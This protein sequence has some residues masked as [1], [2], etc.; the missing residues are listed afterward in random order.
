MSY[1]PGTKVKL[2]EFEGKTVPLLV[3]PR[4]S[5]LEDYGMEYTYLKEEPERVFAVTGLV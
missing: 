4:R 5:V 2:G 1:P 3:I